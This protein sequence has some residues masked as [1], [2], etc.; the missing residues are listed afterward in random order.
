MSQPVENRLVKI[1]AI[2]FDLDG[3]VYVGN[4]VMPGAIKTIQTLRAMGFKIFFVTNNSGKKREYLAAKLT[5]MGIEASVDDIF[6]SGYAAG[7]LAKQ[8]SEVND[9]VYVIGSN[10]LKEEFVDLGMKIVQ[11]YP[12]NLIVVGIDAGFNY[13]M[14]TLSLEILRG[15]ATFIVCNRD[16]N[17]PI[18][19]GKFLPGCGSIVA[20]IE[21][22]WGGSAHYDVGKPNTKLLEMISIKYDFQPSEILVVGDV[23]DSDIAM[24]KRFG[25]ISVLIP[26]DQQ[27]NV[28]RNLKEKDVNPDFILPKI[29]ELISLFPFASRIS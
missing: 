20:A 7:S 13:E 5:R 2:A 18:E 24:A 3:V 4:T 11:G 9:R 10:D 26:Y 28:Q 21:W 29:E 22:A 12:C 15:G 19:K 14:L 27:N 23:V 16:R 6:S 25:T 17:F 1:K 8:L